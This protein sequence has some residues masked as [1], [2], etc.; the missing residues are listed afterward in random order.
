ML[1]P[2]VVGVI[3]ILLPF[4]SN[5]GE[6]SPARRPWAVAIVLVVVLMIGTLWI[7][8]ERAPWSPDFTA[9]ALPQAVIG[10]VSAEAQRGADLFHQ[11]GCEFC[12]RVAGQGG[13]RG[14]DLTDVASRLTPQQMT[15][16]ILNGATNMPSFAAILKPDELDAIVAFLQTRHGEG[17]IQRLRLTP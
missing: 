9:K 1:G 13:R 14:P 11:K 3:L 15:I 7:E 17:V 12:H 16:R 10:Q 4:V 5:R 6:R 8:G 2:L